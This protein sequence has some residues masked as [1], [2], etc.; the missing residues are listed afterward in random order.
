L[1][2]G[3]YLVAGPIIGSP[4][5]GDDHGDSQL[6]M[7]LA[8]TDQSFFRWW[9][10]LTREWA[11]TTGRYF[12]LNVLHGSAVFYLFQDRES[13]KLYQFFILATA[14]A[15]F[16][17]L[18][19]VTLRSRW[20]AFTAFGFALMTIQMKSW[21]DPFWQFSGQQSLVNILACISLALAVVASRRSTST[22]ALLVAVAGMTV[23]AGAI[24]TYESS[25]FLIAAVPL[26]LLRERGYGVRRMMIFAG[27]AA[28]A[29]ALLINLLVQR[30][31]AVVT[32]P[33]YTVSLDAQ[34]I[35]TTLKHQ[36]GAA[37]PLSYRHHTVDSFL[38]PDAS[39]PLNP[40][41]VIAI[42]LVLAV[43]MS[44]SLV[45]VFRQTRRGLALAAGAALIYWL[46]PSF[47]VAVSL[48]W[49]AEVRPGVGYIP[50]MAGGLAIGWL[51]TLAASRLGRAMR[52]PGCIGAPWTWESRGMLA[53]ALLVGVGVATVVGVTASSNAS[54]V[55]APFITV[56]QIRR[57]AY[58]DAI[59]NG[60]YRGIA[61]SAF[62]GHGLGEWWNWENARFGAW[63]GASP[64]L[65]FV[66][67]QDFP[68]ANC[69]V[70]ECYILVEQNPAPGVITYDLERVTG[71]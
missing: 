69:T 64:D 49:Q 51:L 40:A 13:Y 23:F 43:A 6:P 55:S 14:L 58:I 35:F 21:Y 27:Y 2:L 59:Q 48:R 66:L 65:Q 32:N 47:F 44:V 16:S 62:I 11:A 17:T 19:G 9:I 26:L 29:A 28:V 18:M 57:D 67:P 70:N 63:Y 31:H 24:L 41:L 39:W 25:L 37:V 3:Y 38:P 68:N 15:S 33:G 10:D 60:L 45:Q 71:S 46:V 36:M 22:K 50:V 53:V 61:P 56:Q 1:G 52:A 12:P 34:A 42:C 30:S 5:W 7:I 4:Y 20:A 54:A 8:A